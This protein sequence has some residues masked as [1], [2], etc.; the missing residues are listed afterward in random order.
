M[1]IEQNHAE[2]LNAAREESAK[3]PTSAAQ[4]ARNF[5]KMATPAGV[6][7]LLS[8]MHLF[9]LPFFGIAL[10]LAAL[11]DIFDV[12][13]NASVVLSALIFVFTLMISVVIA[14]CLHIMGA[15]SGTQKRA[16][17]TGKLLNKF[18]RGGPGTRYGLLFAG[19]VIEFIPAVDLLP[20]E[21]TIVIIT[22][23]MLLNER[24]EAKQAA[25][26]KDASQMQESYA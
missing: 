13:A 14:L 10:I 20:I 21:T 8:Q 7:S 26:E 16:K 12:I 18:L 2:N 6:L 9:D 17:K 11:L 5:A 23:I 15:G 25:R 24:R 3:R 1:S 19:T 22:F 4:N